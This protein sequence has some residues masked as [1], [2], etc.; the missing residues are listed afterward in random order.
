MI[1][2]CERTLHHTMMAGFLRVTTRAVLSIILRIFVTEERVYENVRKRETT[3]LDRPRHRRLEVF[4]RKSAPVVLEND[5]N[6]FVIREF[7]GPYSE[8]QAMSM[9]GRR[10]W[11]HTS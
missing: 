3:T 8:F 9:D 10:D 6:W 1:W 7:V 11:P 2:A 4:P 5:S